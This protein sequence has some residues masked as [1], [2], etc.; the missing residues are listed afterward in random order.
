MVESSHVIWIEIAL[1]SG[2][3]WIC[4]PAW[5]GSAFEVP[6]DHADDDRAL[7]DGRRHPFPQPEP[8]V[9]DREHPGKARFERE[10]RA[11]QGPHRTLSVPVQEVLA[12]DDVPCLVA[13]DLG[14]Q[15]LSVRP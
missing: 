9:P 2:T 12:R 5:S 3:A 14:R 11:S 7:A 10:R 1:A 15:P 8:D 13:R 4:G 6:V